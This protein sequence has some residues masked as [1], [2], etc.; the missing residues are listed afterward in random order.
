MNGC[1]QAALALGGDAIT[2]WYVYL[3]V[4]YGSAWVLIGLSIW[5]G[6]RAWAW[7]KEN[8]A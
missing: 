4:E 1:E 3:A 5:G 7:F 6:R 2:A 8:E